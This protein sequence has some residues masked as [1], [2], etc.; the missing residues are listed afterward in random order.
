MAQ[1]SQHYFTVD[2]EDWF[3]TEAAQPIYPPV[4]WYKQIPRIEWTTH[5]LLDLLE[6]HAARATFFVVGWISDRFPRLIKD[7]HSRGHEVASHSYDHLL[8][9]KKKPDAFRSDLLRS[10]K[11]LEDIIG[12]KIAGFRAPMFSVRKKTPWVFEILKEEGFLYDSSVYPTSIRPDR[13]PYDYRTTA[14]QHPNGLWEFPLPVV[15]LGHLQIPSAGGF[16]LRATPLAWTMKFFQTHPESILFI[17]PWE[18]D[19]ESGLHSTLLGSIRQ[20]IGLKDNFRKI[21]TLL[22]N[23]KFSALADRLK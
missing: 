22:Q 15:K 4:T 13:P 3:Q 23:F 9:Y 5:A 2:V 10:K 8:V 7:I 11:S 21:E 12:A 14:Y 19:P 20:N 16:Y 1:S 18:I 17:H 6:K